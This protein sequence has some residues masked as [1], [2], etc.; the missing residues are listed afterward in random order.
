MN[1]YE[2]ARHKIEARVYRDAVGEPPDSKW[3]IIVSLLT[4]YGY[5]SRV[6]RKRLGLS[7]PL[8]TEDRRVIEQTIFPYYH[9][10]TSFKTV[11]FVGCNTYTLSAAILREPR[12]LDD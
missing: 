1:W 8:N 5:A 6:L 12:L 2:R 7:T 3:K 11:L 9:A 4:E 10:D